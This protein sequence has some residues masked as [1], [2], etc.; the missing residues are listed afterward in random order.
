MFIDKTSIRSILIARM[1]KAILI[2]KGLEKYYKSAEYKKNRTSTKNAKMEKLIFKDS[3]L[4]MTP[5]AKNTNTF[6][7]YWKIFCPLNSLKK[8]SFI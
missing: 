2:V 6:F 3:L 8:L 1:W 5:M 7:D 4:E